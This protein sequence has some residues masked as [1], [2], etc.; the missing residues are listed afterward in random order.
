MIRIKNNKVLDQA[1]R[2]VIPISI[3]SPLRL[4]F[5]FNGFDRREKERLWRAA[6]WRNDGKNTNDS[7]PSSRYADCRRVRKSSTLKVQ[8]TLIFQNNNSKMV[9]SKENH[10]HPKKLTNHFCICKKFSFPGHFFNDMLITFWDYHYYAKLIFSSPL[11]DLTIFHIFTQSRS[12]CNALSFLWNVCEANTIRKDCN[13]AVHRLFVNYL[14]EMPTP[15]CRREKNK[16]IL[17]LLRRCVWR[18]GTWVSFVEILL[19]NA[20]RLAET[21]VEAVHNSRA[22]DERPKSR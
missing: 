16:K 9:L 22:Y 20:R 21:L 6:S 7:C 5:E 10:M 18:L 8:K 11:T 2:V 14:I 15:S 13:N 4:P 12:I 3:T 17:I 1:R 19:C